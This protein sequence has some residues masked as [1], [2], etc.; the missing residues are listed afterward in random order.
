[1]KP[2]AYTL[3]PS[4]K[5]SPKFIFSFLLLHGLLFLGIEYILFTSFPIFT[6]LHAFIGIVIYLIFWRAFFPNLFKDVLLGACISVLMSILF[7]DILLDNFFFLYQEFPEGFI[8]K[9]YSSLVVFYLYFYVA[10]I[11]RV[12]FY[13]K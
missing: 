6:L 12:I 9:V 10:L 1:M 8:P 13:K 5:T 4:D 11:R 3:T 7:G 2:Q